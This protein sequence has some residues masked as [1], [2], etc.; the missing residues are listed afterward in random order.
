MCCEYKLCN[1]C[2]SLRCRTAVTLTLIFAPSAAVH[3]ALL[4][5][6]INEYLSGLGILW[7]GCVIA[8]LAVAWLSTQGTILDTRCRS[9]MPYLIYVRLGQSVSLIPLAVIV[10]LLQRHSA[11]TG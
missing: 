8:E 10:V 11:Q 6:S 9:I 7:I 4:L 3:K 5:F 2:V 1:E